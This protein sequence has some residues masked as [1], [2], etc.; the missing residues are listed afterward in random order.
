MAALNEIIFEDLDASFARGHYGPFAVVLR[1]ADGYVNA[2][3]LAAR[4][5]KR[6]DNWLANK[7]SRELINAVAAQLAPVAPSGPALGATAVVTGGAIPETRG[8]YVH[9]LLVPHI[10]SWVSTD[11]AIRASEIVNAALVREYREAL[12]AKDDQIDRLEAALARLQASADHTGQRVEHLVSEVSGV[13]QQNDALVSEVS[14]V[15][16]QNDA[17]VSAVQHVKKQNSMLVGAATRTL[18]A[19]NELC[20]LA[21]ATAR[22]A[23]A[24]PGDLGKEES[25]A[26]LAVT[27]ELQRRQL[28]VARCQARALPAAVLDRRRHAQEEARVR[29][30]SEAQRRDCDEQT[31]RR[32]QDMVASR[33][34]VDT[35]FVLSCVPNARHL[36][37]RIR[38]E[39]QERVTAA[40]GAPAAI[41]LD[42]MSEGDFERLAR[43]L[44]GEPQV[45]C[46]AAA[47]A[48][49]RE[50]EK[51]ADSVGAAR[52]QS[53]GSG[54]GLPGPRGK[55]APGSP[56]AAAAPELPASPSRAPAAANPR[57][58][59]EEFD[60][61]LDELL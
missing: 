35:V 43:R 58:T 28:Y 29:A 7:G 49:H 3:K 36:W 51:L 4:G 47:G 56:G 37:H 13:R 15:R 5:H 42:G 23:V 41:R 30:L 50:A 53:Q 31:Q 46:Q 1:K 25:F 17:L 52:A 45:A 16:Q 54:V 60:E 20:D 33:V 48:I 22:D 40:P 34:R 38:E 9:P 14:G 27:D 26:L 11:F 24:R 6:F 2:T 61:L 44:H 19:V 18:G 59:P 32:L 10:A 55:A 57:L 8:T 39:A 21:A 12:R